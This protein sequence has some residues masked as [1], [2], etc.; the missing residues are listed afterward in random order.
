MCYLKISGLNKYELD[1]L[2]FERRKYNDLTET[3]TKLNMAL[4]R[5]AI[6]SA[7]QLRVTAVSRTWGGGVRMWGGR[8]SAVVGR[9]LG[10]AVHRR[11][12]HPQPG[13]RPQVVR[14][15]AVRVRY[16]LV[17]LF[18]VRGHSLRCRVVR[19]HKRPDVAA[20]PR[21]HVPF[22]RPVLELLPVLGRE[23]C[24]ALHLE[25]VPGHGR[26]PPVHAHLL[27]RPIRR[28]EPESV[29]GFE[30][31][32]AGGQPDRRLR[33]LTTLATRLPELLPAVQVQLVDGHHRLVVVPVRQPAGRRELTV[34]GRRTILLR[35][36]L[37]AS[38]ASPVPISRRVI[39]YR[40]SQIST[41]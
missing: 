7:K 36:P 25:L 12:V 14:A 16:V 5:R 22:P 6:F 18:R 26:V 30:R 39:N 1:Q 35:V 3:S 8:V 20:L 11:L 15:P 34:H 19:A 21:C 2:F 40:L 31:R 28:L 38:A 17:V 23:L 4:N 9:L 37:A 13:A 32:W 33:R 29:L 10:F 24:I 41:F 27:G